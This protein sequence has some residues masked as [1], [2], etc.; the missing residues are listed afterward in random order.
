[1]LKTKYAV[2]TLSVKT[3]NTM[4]LKKN[5]LQQNCYLYLVNIFVSLTF[6]MKYMY[7]WNKFLVFIKIFSFGKGQ[8]NSNGIFR[9]IIFYV[10]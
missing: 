5:I 10:W 8:M 9:A 6:Y 3:K 2:N 4:K 1:M 7:F